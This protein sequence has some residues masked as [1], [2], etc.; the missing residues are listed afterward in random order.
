M[1]ALSSC[2]H[3]ASKEQPAP[4]A[5]ASGG[6]EARALNRHFDEQIARSRKLWQSKPSLGECAVLSENPDRELCKT[7]GTSLTALEQP[8]DATAEQTLA[9]LSKAA[10]ALA[11]L[12]KRVRYLSL[13]ELAEHRVQSDAGASRPMEI[14]EGPISRLM[15]STVRLERDVMRELG[16]YLEYAE[17]PVRRKAFEIVKALQAQHPQWPLLK[18]TIR[19]AKLLEREPDLKAQLVA[20]DASGLPEGKPPGQSPFSK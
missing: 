2:R 6:F 13:A 14:V 16:A 18:Q 4:R 8:S 7:A 17:P 5:S 9:A 10:L 19:E 15:E 1:L 12:S 11:R 20:L 3:E